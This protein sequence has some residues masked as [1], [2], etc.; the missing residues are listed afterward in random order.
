MY[1]SLSLYIYT[2]IYIYMSIDIAGRSYRACRSYRVETT[3]REDAA[4]CS[5]VGALHANAEIN[6]FR[7]RLIRSVPSGW[8]SIRLIQLFG[9]TMYE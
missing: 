6:S 3:R 7:L 8:C 9:S 4:S 5:A 1:T 2:Y